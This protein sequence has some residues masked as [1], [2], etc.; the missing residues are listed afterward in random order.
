MQFPKFDWK[1][2]DW[3]SPKPSKERAVIGVAVLAA[4][5]LGYY[6]FAPSGQGEEPPLQ[7]QA[8]M[9]SQGT[10]QASTGLGGGGGPVPLQKVSQG[11]CSSEAPEGWRVTDTNQQGTV[12]SLASADGGEI[13]SYD[14]VA[15]NGGQAM[16]YYG[17]QFRT[18]ESY[19]LYMVQ[20]L[21]NEQPQMTGHGEQVGPYQVIHFATSAHEG[22]VLYYRFAIPADPQGY[23][24]M[25]RIAIGRA[26]D[27]KSV[28]MAG[29]VAAAAR[30]SAILIPRPSVNYEAPRD[31]SHGAGKSGDDGDLAGTYNAQLGRG[32]AHDPETGR[33]YNVD[34]TTDWHDTGPEG[35]GYYGP[36][37]RKL[38][39][40]MQ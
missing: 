36:T 2:I 26:G 4:G 15:V 34:V 23:G 39:G 19:I 31:R 25:V 14:G 13:A 5:A 28:A 24:M 3:F 21:T 16:G 7:S 12:F 17:D 30:C 33:N 8:V 10:P 22:Y 38:V 35:S 29:S 27:Q 1:H 6:V 20:A 18:P 37:G 11:Q 40:G 9:P 32:W